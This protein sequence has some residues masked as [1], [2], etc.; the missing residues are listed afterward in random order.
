MSFRVLTVML[1]CMSLHQCGSSPSRRR[2]WSLSC[3]ISQDMLFATRRARQGQKGIISCVDYKRQGPSAEKLFACGSYSQSVCT[4]AADEEARR[5]PHQ[6]S[7]IVK[8]VHSLLDEETL[9]WGG[10]TQVSSRRGR[11][12]TLSLEKEENE[13]VGVHAHRGV[14]R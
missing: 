10:V 3:L 8:P 1:K 2:R 12:N 11:A 5:R 7:A 6:H 13:N 9:P 14:A 4:Y